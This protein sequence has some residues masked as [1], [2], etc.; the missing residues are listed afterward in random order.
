M[1]SFHLS[2]YAICFAPC[3]KYTVHRFLSLKRPH[4]SK[5]NYT[6]KNFVSTVCSTK[7]CTSFANLYYIEVQKHTKWS[8]WCSGRSAT[9]TLC[10]TDIVQK[11][12]FNSHLSTTNINKAQNENN[13]CKKPRVNINELGQRNIQVHRTEVKGHLLSLTLMWFNSMNIL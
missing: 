9:W 4:F 1:L 13:K 10:D 2:T 8:Q 6:Y 5:L 12:I 7:N 3:N 11:L